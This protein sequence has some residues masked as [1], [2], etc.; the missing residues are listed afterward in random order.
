MLK[1]AERVATKHTKLLTSIASTPV[2]KDSAIVSC[3]TLFNVASLWYFIDKHGEA[4]ELLTQLQDVL[5]CDP[6]AST[7]LGVRVKFTLANSHRLV[8][9]RAKDPDTKTKHYTVAARLFQETYNDSTSQYGVKDMR[10]LTCEYKKILCQQQSGEI[11]NPEVIERYEVLLRAFETVETYDGLSIA[12]PALQS[13]FY[14]ERSYV[15]NSIAGLLEESGEYDRAFELLSH[16][17]EER[18]ARNGDQDRNTIQS[19]KNLGNFL[20]K[21]KKDPA[22]ARPLLQ[23]AYNGASENNGP[24]NFYT[25]KIKKLLDE[26]SDSGDS[27]QASGLGR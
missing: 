12:E 10:P 1:E 19:L 15:Q 8:A 11:N 20:L 13:K 4:I 23:L 7:A 25:K 17:C 16:L 21:V 14:K 2:Q 3:T 9:D 24:Q 26:C 27:G 5:V 6:D 18:R 22:K